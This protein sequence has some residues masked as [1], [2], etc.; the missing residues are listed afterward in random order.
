MDTLELKTTFAEITTRE[1]QW[2]HAYRLWLDS[3][4]HN[5]RRAYERAWNDMLTHINRDPWE[6][7]ASGIADWQKELRRRGIVETGVHQR[8][9]AVSSFFSYTNRSYL[10]H[11]TDGREAP[12]HRYN[13]VHAIPRTRVSPYAHAT[14]LTPQAARKLLDAIKRDSLQ[15]QRDYALFLTYIL[16]GRRNNEIIGLHWGDFKVEGERVF[17]RWSGKGKV[18]QRYELPAVVWNAILEYVLNSRPYADLT[19]EAFIFIALN[20]NGK[21]FAPGRAQVGEEHGLSDRMVRSLLKKYARKAGLEN[22][23]SLRVHDLRHTAAMLRKAAGDDIESICAMLGHES[24][25]VTQ[26]YL[27][28]LEGHADTSWQAAAALMGM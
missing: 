13:P 8:L 18:E 15:G 4:A 1:Q 20:E 17:Y 6:I 5:T 2:A 3:K 14:Y 23:A 9:A 21:R 24:V 11:D 16:T 26:L 7:T 19:P 28:K 25:A 22:W 27:H 10:V 12:L